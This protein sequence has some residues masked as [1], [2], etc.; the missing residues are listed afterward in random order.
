M[1][2]FLSINNFTHLYKTVKEYSID[3]Y[4]KKIDYKK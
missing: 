3:R 2:D 1:E 4:N